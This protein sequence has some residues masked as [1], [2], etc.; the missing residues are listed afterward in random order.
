M[1]DDST[2]DDSE[3][4]ILSEDADV[5]S[6]SLTVDQVLETISNERR[7]Y[8][9]KYFHQTDNDTAAL[10]TLIDYVTTQEFD[11]TPSDRE[12]EELSTSIYHVHLPYLQDV[13]LIEYDERSDRVR[14]YHH[15]VVDEWLTAIANRNNR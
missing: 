15:P 8:I 4:E 14:F 9:L 7:R 3:G 6:P 1:S 5:Q 12:R 11:S 13:G 2:N 10:D